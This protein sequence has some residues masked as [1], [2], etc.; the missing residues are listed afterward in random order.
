S[1]KE[2]RHCLNSPQ[3]MAKILRLILACSILH[4]VCIQDTFSREWHPD[5]E[6]DLVAEASDGLGNEGGEHGGRARR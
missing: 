4:N 3:A 5:M 1:L 2:I 6:E